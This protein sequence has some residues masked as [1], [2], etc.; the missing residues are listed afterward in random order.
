MHIGFFTEAYVPQLNG[1]ATSLEVLASEI[2]KYGHCVNIFAPAMGSYIDLRPRVYRIPSLLAVKDPPLWMATP[3][4]TKVLTEIPKLRLDT[5]HIHT[6]F[7][8]HFLG[9]QVARH[10]RLPLVSTFHTLL[11]AHVNTVKIF[12]RY[13]WPRRLAEVFSMWTCNMCDHIIAPSQKI[14]DLLQGYGVYRPITVI[15][16]GIPIERFQGRQRGYLRSR[17]SL[18]ENDKIL[19]G[20]GRLTQ[21]KNFGFLIN[22]L[23]RLVEKDKSIYLA[24]IGMGHLKD[25][26][27]SEASK[28]GVLE[29]VL[30]CGPIEPQQM[31]NVYADADVYVTASLTEVHS[32]AALEGL[33]SGLPMVVAR[34]KSFESMVLH[35]QNGFVADLDVEM[36][37]TRILDIVEHPEVMRCMRTHSLGIA[38]GFSIQTQAEKLLDL[39]SDLIA[40]NNS[41]RRQ[42][43]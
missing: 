21:D 31:P 34:D 3:V 11:S 41:R 42:K 12:G 9:Y 16:N 18:C 14:R 32:V 35:G 19:V 39:Y 10:E 33:A 43:R 26:L 7:M 23:A 15:H 4:S 29:N 1:V 27:K 37:A 40:Q 20:V 22:V 2:E 13:P 8:L 17:F 36:F 28:L 6:P 24:L 25:S 38:R 5:V 30:F